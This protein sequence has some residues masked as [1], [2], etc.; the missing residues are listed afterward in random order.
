MY[1]F[2]LTCTLALVLHEFTP[3]CYNTPVELYDDVTPVCL[4]A[5]NHVTKHKSKQTMT[6]V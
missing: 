5:S 6:S 3:A 1:F 4:S 2:H